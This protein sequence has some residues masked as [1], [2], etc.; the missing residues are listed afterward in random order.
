MGKINVE[1]SFRD[2]RGE[3]ADLIE[4]E[5]INSVT[6]LSFVKGAVRGNH[7]HKQTTQ[8]N[9]VISGQIKLVSQ[10]P[11]EQIMETVM[12][13]GELTVSKPNER[14]AL[15][16]LEDSRLLVFTKGPRGGKE[17]ESDTFRLIDPLVTS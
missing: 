10:F 11:G 15:V 7:Y 4:N 13:L 14:H 2:E 9:Y 17:Y 12:E 5:N 3:I 8:W 6:F 16:A 1:T